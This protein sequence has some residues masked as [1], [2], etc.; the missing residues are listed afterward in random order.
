MFDYG[1][2][3]RVVGLTAAELL[4]AGR[5]DIAFNLRGGFHHAHPGRAGGFCFLNDVALACDALARAGKRVACVDVDAHHGDGTQAMFYDRDDVL[6]IS[7]HADPNFYYPYFWGHAQETGAGKGQG[8]NLNLP[9]P[10]GSPQETC[11]GNPRQLSPLG[12]ANGF[13]QQP[14]RPARMEQPVRQ[15]GEA[16][17]PAGHGIEPRQHPVGRVEAVA[18]D[19]LGLGLNHQLGNIDGGWAF[20]AALL[21]VHAQVGDSLQLI[22]GERLRVKLAGDHRDRKS[23]RLNSSHRT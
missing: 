16:R 15:R 23:T 4:L 10:L 14:P 18:G 3:A 6:T 1:A 12:N 2:W 13:F 20:Q 7:I 9:L 17:R 19:V 22:F 8:F 11:G 5:A 21:A